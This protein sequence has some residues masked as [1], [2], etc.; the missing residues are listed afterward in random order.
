M[1]LCGEF[2]T[3]KLLKHDNFRHDRATKPTE[4]RFISFNRTNAMQKCSALSTRVMDKIDGLKRFE[5]FMDGAD[6]KTETASKKFSSPLLRPEEYMDN[7]ASH[8]AN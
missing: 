7:R 6:S 8:A 5:M 3:K 2:G 4:N 1:G